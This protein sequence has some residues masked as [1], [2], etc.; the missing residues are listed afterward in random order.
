M[1]YGLTLIL[2]CKEFPGVELKI[3]MP[4][5]DRT[6][7]DAENPALKAAFKELDKVLGLA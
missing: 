6:H 4:E 7:V 2:T 1:T 3:S 5:I